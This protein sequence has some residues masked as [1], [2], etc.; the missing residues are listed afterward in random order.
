M[1]DEKTEYG[2]IK[3]AIVSLKNPLIDKINIVDV[4]QGEMEREGRKKS[5]SI[6]VR[7]QPLEK[8]LNDAEIEKMCANIISEVGEKVSGMLKS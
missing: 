8:T 2:A 4:F 3:R 6:R 7:F 5:L 1:I